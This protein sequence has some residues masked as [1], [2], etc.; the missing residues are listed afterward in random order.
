MDD[1]MDY[2]DRLTE[3]YSRLVE[4]GDTVI[5]VGAYTGR[6]SKHYAR[7]VGSGGHVFC[8][9]ALPETYVR[10]AIEMMRLTNVTPVNV[11]LG[12]TRG[13]HEFVKAI[14]APEESGLRKRHIYNSPDTAT[15]S[16]HVWVETLDHFCGDLVS[17]RYIKIDVEG[18][19]LSVLRGSENL[20]N[21]CRPIVSVEWG[22]PTYK[23]YDL[24]PEDMWSWCYARGYVIYDIHL[25]K[26]DEF[27]R[28]NHVCE[29]DQ[30]VWDF[31][32]VPG[33]QEEDFS[34]RVST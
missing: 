18:A 28:W 15:L 11:A 25:E 26:I 5:D 2:E 14:G 23:A 24:T 29:V 3:T 6:H 21:R 13:L 4:D 30:T 22:L 34:S 19:E 7:L 1:V 27:D 33:E 9:E 31:W 10:L 32:L 12:E 17:P 8:F 16:R 20:V